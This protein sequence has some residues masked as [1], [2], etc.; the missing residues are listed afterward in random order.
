MKPVVLVAEPVGLKVEP[1]GLA[2]GIAAEA[3]GLRQ[4]LLPT[5]TTYWVNQA[6]FASWVV[7][8]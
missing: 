7:T 6:P 3:T 1:T 2:A 8:L 4:F 5:Q